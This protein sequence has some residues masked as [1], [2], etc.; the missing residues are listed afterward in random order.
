MQIIRSPAEA[1]AAD[2]ELRQLI[3]DT[4]ARVAACPEIL[5]FVLVVDPSDT[6]ANIDRQFGF[7]F[8]DNSNELILEPPGCFRLF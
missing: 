4:F 2:P 3:S 5:G 7:S 1:D 6:L 8:L